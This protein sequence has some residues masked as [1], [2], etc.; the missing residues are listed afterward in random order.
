M[1]SR[2]KAQIH[3]PT[4]TS[5]QKIIESSGQLKYLRD[6]LV[7]RGAKTTWRHRYKTV[8][9]KY[10]WYLMRDDSL[11][12]QRGKGG[13]FLSPEEMASEA[14]GELL[15]VL[16]SLGVRISKPTKE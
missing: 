10:Y 14:S 11:R 6:I 3:K 5:V 15:E 16:E 13:P 7:G 12:Y 1:Y 4:S 2:K 9:D 8:D